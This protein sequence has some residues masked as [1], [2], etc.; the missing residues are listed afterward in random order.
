MRRH[1]V[2]PSSAP[3]G[4]GSEATT[5]RVHPSSAPSCPAGAPGRGSL[6]P[7]SSVPLDWL[8]GWEAAQLRQAA[9]DKGLTARD[10]A[11]AGPSPSPSLPLS[12]AVEKESAEGS[13]G[14]EVFKSTASSVSWQT[15][16]P[17][18]QHCLQAWAHGL[19]PTGTAARPGLRPP[20]ELLGC[21][22]LSTP[23]PGFRF[24]RSRAGLPVRG[25]SYRDEVFPG[26]RLLIAT[27]Q[28]SRRRESK[29]LARVIPPAGATQ[30]DNEGTEL[31]LTLSPVAV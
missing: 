21:L 1:Y 13:L 6:P 31:A 4:V 20:L 10:R 23:A 2:Y 30:G 7:V 25:V 26:C 3:F 9:A 5:P 8:R 12:S 14:T 28:G 24:P 18:R 17:A 19:C 27:R 29:L 16:S 15:E 22:E 11:G